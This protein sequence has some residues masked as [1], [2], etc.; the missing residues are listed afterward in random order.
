MRTPVIKMLRADEIAWRVERPPRISLRRRAAVVFFKGISVLRKPLTEKQR[1]D[2]SS[3]TRGKNLTP[4]T[5]EECPTG[6]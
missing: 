3:P 6:R 4:R 5:H 2:N 1:N